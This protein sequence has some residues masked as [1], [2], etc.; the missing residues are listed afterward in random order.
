MN[1]SPVP[2]MTPQMTHQLAPP[3]AML[4]ELTHRCPLKCPYCSNPLALDRARDELDTASWKRVIT[5]AAGIGI[6]QAHF[7]GGEPMVRSD[8]PE[9]VR[10]ARAEGLYTN[11]ITSAVLLNQARMAELAEA[12]L[13][14]VQI[15]FQGADAAV[16]DHV[17]GFRD[18][19]V[20]KLAA[21]RL[22]REAGLALTLN[23]VVH[24]QN[25][26]QLSAMIDLAVAAGAQR[27]E[28]AHV[29]YYGWALKNRAALIPTRAQLDE[30]TRIVTAA[31]ASLAGTLTIDYVVPDYYAARPKACMGGWARQ[32]FNITPSGKMLPCHAAETIPGLVFERVTERSVGEIWANSTAFQKYRGTDWMAPPCK[33]CARAEID[34]GGCRCQALALTG[35]AGATDPACGLSPDHAMMAALAIAESGEAIDDF[36]YRIIS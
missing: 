36:A 19:H 34:W 29:Q 8:L 6:L 4:M 21:A 15:S 28:V 7:S 9:L 10:H 30:A 27:I 13:D 11:L 1:D 20:K 12:G 26:H 3:L 17:A 25:L 23:A 18:A 5:E 31:R 24:R 22:V 2:Q 16:A 33:G 32:F 14:H 35:D